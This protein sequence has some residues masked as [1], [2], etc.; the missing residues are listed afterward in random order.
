LTLLEA[1]IAFYRKQDPRPALDKSRK[2]LEEM[3]YWGLLPEWERVAAECG[4]SRQ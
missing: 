1:R 3:G 4:Y 2:R